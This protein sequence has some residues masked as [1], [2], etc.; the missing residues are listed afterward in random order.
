MNVLDVGEATRAASRPTAR[1]RSSAPSL[2]SSAFVSKIPTTFLASVSAVSGSKSSSVRLGPVEGGDEFSEMDHAVGVG[3]VLGVGEER[4]H[5]GVER[6][7]RAGRGRD[8]G[9]AELHGVRRLGEAVQ[10]HVLLP[11]PGGDEGDHADSGDGF[12]AVH[13]Y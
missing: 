12:D 11:K 10:L 4:V 5:G 8:L 9:L 7:D 1:R 13:K 2:E 6:R 3:R